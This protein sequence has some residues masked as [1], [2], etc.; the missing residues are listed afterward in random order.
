MAGI[1]NSENLFESFKKY[2]GLGNAQGLVREFLVTLKNAGVEVA[3]L[4]EGHPQSN[5]R[6][7]KH[8]DVSVAVIAKESGPTAQDGFWGVQENIVEQLKRRKIRWGAVF[9]RRTQEG[10][11]MDVGFSVMGDDFEKILEGSQTPS[12][13]GK[14]YKFHGCYLEEK[15]YIQK[16]HTFAELKSLRLLRGLIG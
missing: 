10:N 3:E 12:G 13:D 8:G 9:L 11:D 5:T 16:F 2:R 7:L 6:M 4:N 15:P 1:E 14:A